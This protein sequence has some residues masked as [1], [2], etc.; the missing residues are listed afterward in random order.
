MDIFNPYRDGYYSDSDM[1]SSE[2][3]INETYVL[4]LK[5]SIEVA[6]AKIDPISSLDSG[7]ESGGMVSSEKHSRMCPENE[8][9]RCP[10]PAS[11]LPEKLKIFRGHKQPDPVV[12]L[13]QAKNFLSDEDFHRAPN[14]K[15]RMHDIEAYVEYLED[16]KYQ[17]D[18][19]IMKTIKE[20]IEVHRDWIKEATQGS[21]PSTT[22]V[23]F[24]HS[25]RL[26][27]LI[28]DPQKRNQIADAS[29]ARRHV[30]PKCL[31][32]GASVHF[33][34]NRKT[35]P[36]IGCPDPFYYTKEVAKYR[37]TKDLLARD[38]R[39]RYAEDHADDVTGVAALPNFNGPYT[40]INPK[41]IED[42][43]LNRQRFL[44]KV[45]ERLADAEWYA[46]RALLRDVLVAITNAAL[47]NPDNMENFDPVTKVDVD[48]LLMLTLP[49]RSSR[50]EIPV[51]EPH[52]EYDKLVV[53]AHQIDELAAERAWAG[54]NA[55]IEP[56]VFLNML[57]NRRR[58]EAALNRNEGETKTRTFN[59]TF[60]DLS[61]LMPI[62][63]QA[64]RI[65]CVQYPHE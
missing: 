10:N 8:S 45:W 3:N 11:Q 44:C 63:H 31:T 32:K 1:A 17:D 7:F 5:G 2:D 49:S 12:R 39:L 65:R 54:P 48:F 42:A 40:P 36:E 28:K 16:N 29:R 14:F 55:I 33:K 37:R 60:Y 13:R 52:T 56:L 24:C 26:I 23:D 47:A 61:K 53:L 19:K 4:D 25:N 59:W 27:H 57:N 6:N 35:D 21:E 43:L 50:I 51:I 38:A 20:M 62:L 58:E 15:E 41:A 9:Q 46:P 18:K 30:L 64:R 34:I 22:A